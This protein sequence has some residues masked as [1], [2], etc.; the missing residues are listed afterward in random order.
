VPISS[1]G[2]FVINAQVSIPSICAQPIVL[3][4]IGTPAA[5]GPW[6]AASELPGKDNKEKD[7]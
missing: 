7:N 1:D 5:A 3:I 6:I 2:D 4:R